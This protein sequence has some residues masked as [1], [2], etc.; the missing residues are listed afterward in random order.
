MTLAAVSRL[1]AE[2]PWQKVIATQSDEVLAL[3]P[4][5][6]IRRITRKGGEVREWKVDEARLSPDE[7]RRFTYHVRRRRGDAGF[8]RCWLLVEGETEFWV[9]PELARRCGYDLA[10]EGIECVEFAQCGLP[11]I[12]K[13]AKD[14]GIEWHVIADGDRAGTLY[15]QT[16]QRFVAKGEPQR[17]RITRMPEPDI[18]HCFWAHGYR[19]VYLKA[20]GG[21]P[22]ADADATRVIGQAVS[23]Y[24]KPYLAFELIEAL[25]SGEDRGVPAPIRDAIESCVELARSGAGAAIAKSAPRRPRR[26]RP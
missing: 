14:F 2:I 22:R 26:R 13:V 21:A 17:L 23:R 4:L 6:C 15:A 10:L 8:A 3:A 11:P 19:D 9:L 5:H 20:A 24:S 18:E 12:I 25:R 16:A 7:L 1:L